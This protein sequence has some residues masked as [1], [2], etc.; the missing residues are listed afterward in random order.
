[1]QKVVFCLGCGR[2][3]GRN[4]VGY[5]MTCGG[6]CHQPECIFQYVQY[7]EKRKEGYCNECKLQGL[8]NASEHDQGRVLPGIKD[9]D[10]EERSR[11]WV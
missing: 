11:S 7:T 4:I 9:V 8:H 1:M 2:K 5:V 10:R 3:Y 6:T